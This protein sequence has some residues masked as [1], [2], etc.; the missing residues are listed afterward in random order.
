MS[1][2]GATLICLIASRPLLVN[3]QQYGGEESYDQAPANYQSENGYQQNYNGPE[4][5]EAPASYGQDS[6]SN[7]G[8]SH[9]SGGQERPRIKLN[10]GVHIPAMKIKMPQ[11]NMPKITIKA[12]VRKQNR[13][14]TIHVPEIMVDSSS[15]LPGPQGSHKDYSVPSSSNYESS[16]SNYGSSP[17]SYQDTKSS[18]NYGSPDSSYEPSYQGAN[19]QR[20]HAPLEPGQSMITASNDNHDGL[21]SVSMSANP[22]KE[23]YQNQGYGQQSYGSNPQYGQ[24]P[25]Q[26][27]QGE[28]YSQGQSNGQ[29]STYTQ[30]QY[31]GQVSS[32]GQSQ[33]LKQ[34]PSYS[35]PPQYSQP[36]HNQGSV[37]SQEQVYGTQD[38]ASN[39]GNELSN[40]SPNQ[41]TNYKPRQQEVATPNY[42]SGSSHS[43]GTEQQRAVPSYGYPEL[44]SYSQNSAS[45]LFDQSQSHQSNPQSM[46][47]Y[48]SQPSNYVQPSVRY[49]PARQQHKQVY[50]SFQPTQQSSGDYQPQNYQQ[51]QASSIKASR[52]YK[53][54]ASAI[55]QQQASSNPYQHQA[56]QN[57]YAVQPMERNIQRPSYAPTLPYS[58][59]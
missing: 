11:M 22:P 59:H 28:Y 16:S 5:D 10:L 9:G 25:S 32:Y 3:G 56:T 31:N 13:P 29:S 41:Q 8:G 44:Q 33:L 4:Y 30:N 20:S 36:A 48:V 7:E 19:S 37:Y 49:V 46:H 45:P 57:I 39:V 24:G 38:L 14:M 15:K 40:Y 55:Y 21:T 26:Y 27:N 1:L 2:V 47:A 54:N 35:Q 43:G 52:Q 12:K 58:Q 34:N 50:Q 6:Y 53:P 18:P 23:Q 51:M 17:A 42:G